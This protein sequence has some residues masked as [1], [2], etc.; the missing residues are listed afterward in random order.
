VSNARTTS[1]RAISLARTRPL[2]SDIR[3][4]GSGSRSQRLSRQ[5]HSAPAVCSP[6][7]PHSSTITLAVRASHHRPFPVAWTEYR[8]RFSRTIVSRLSPLEDL[9]FRCKQCYSRATAMLVAPVIFC[10][11]NDATKVEIRSATKKLAS[12]FPTVYVALLRADDHVLVGR[13]RHGVDCPR[14]FSREFF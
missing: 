6:R 11:G 10:C 13:S 8:C 9:L 7:I 14:E 1:E 5:N 12:P 3:R 2:S 4:P